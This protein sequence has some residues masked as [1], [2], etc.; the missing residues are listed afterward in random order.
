MWCSPGALTV[1]NSPRY[2]AK[3]EAK[4]ALYCVAQITQRNTMIALILTLG[5]LL[6]ISAIPAGSI[7]V[8]FA[9]PLIETGV[10]GSLLYLVLNN[11]EKRFSALI[12]QSEERYAALLHEMAEVMKKDIESRAAAMKEWENLR[13]SKFCIYE[14]GEA[15]A[16]AAQVVKMQQ[17]GEAE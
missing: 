15:K 5:A 8:S 13:S 3:V 10:L 16:I 6:Q 9:R 4:F 2:R 1:I 12:K 14:I 11:Q 7:D 17:K